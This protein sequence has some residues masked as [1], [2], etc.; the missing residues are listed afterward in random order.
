MRLPALNVQT[1]RIKAGKYLVTREDGRKFIALFAPHYIGAKRG[2]WIIEA[3]DTLSVD[4]APTLRC[5]VTELAQRWSP[6][7]R[8]PASSA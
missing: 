2:K 7:S 3:Q 8:E 5:A 1:R 4:D 6:L